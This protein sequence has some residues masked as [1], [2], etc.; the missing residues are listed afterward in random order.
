MSLLPRWTRPALHPNNT[1]P[2]F[3]RDS[4]VGRQSGLAP[5]LRN[6]GRCRPLGHIQRRECAH[7]ARQS[8]GI[9]DFREIRAAARPRNRFQYWCIA[10]QHTLFV[11]HIGFLSWPNH[12]AV[13]VTGFPEG[14]SAVSDRVT[15]SAKKNPLKLLENYRRGLF[16][17][18]RPRTTGTH[19]VCHAF[20]HDS[21]FCR[22]PFSYRPG[23]RRK[24][25][26][27]PLV[28]TPSGAW[29]NC[30][31]LLLNYYRTPIYWISSVISVT[32]P[33]GTNKTGTAIKHP[34]HDTS[35]PNPDKPLGHPL[36]PLH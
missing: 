7:D 8:A 15:R 14:F 11:D 22:F 31:G 26:D 35:P 23:H 28:R 3:D 1:L 30:L 10:L 18:F 12:E 20:L 6:T 21:K 13:R 25:S 32:L 24:E 16:P 19:P 36:L 34:P 2:R 27:V 29:I 17:V 5:P 9:H 33:A 4:S